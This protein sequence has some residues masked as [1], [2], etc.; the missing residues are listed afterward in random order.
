MK[1]K[2]IPRPSFSIDFFNRYSFIATLLLLSISAFAQIPNDHCFDWVRQMDADKNSKGIAIA[3]DAAGNVYSTG[4]FLGT[5]DFD[6]TTGVFN[7][8]ALGDKEDI[9][10]SK[11]DANGNF[12]W[13]K[14]MGGSLED[15]STE[16][17]VDAAGNVFTVGYFRG[18]AD[19]DPSPNSF[20]LITSNTS[21]SMFF[22]KLDTDGN[23]V[24]AKLIEGPTQPSDLTLD[25]M[26]NIYITGSFHGI[27]D[28][29]PGP[30][31][32]N[33]AMGWAQSSIF[34]LK[35][36]PTGNLAWVK[37]MGGVNTTFMGGNGGSAIR[38]DVFG[39]I[40]ISGYFIGSVDFDPGPGVFNLIVPPSGWT[41]VFVAKLNA[42]GNF[43][44][45]KQIGVGGSY[46]VRGLKL[47]AVGNV[48]TTGFFSKAL[49]FDPGPNVFN[50]TPSSSGSNAY[51][52]KLNAA[53]DFV[54][55]IQMGA[56][57]GAESIV[58]DNMDN[59]Y[60]IGNFRGNADFDPGPGVYNLDATLGNGMF[61][62]KLDALGGF[63]WAKKISNMDSEYDVT[64]LDLAMD[65][66]GCF[67][68]IG[69]FR[70][71]VDFD[72]SA[73]TNVLFTEVN[74]IFAHKMCPCLSVSAEEPF[75]STSGF[76]HSQAYPNP[77]TATTTI[78]YELPV[79]TVV[80]LTV[81]DCFGQTVAVLVD[82]HQTEGAHK[83]TFSAEGLPAGTYFYRLEAGSFREMGKI[84]VQ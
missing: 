26:G 60:T 83:A 6:P 10:V 56:L 73:G 52:L 21:I 67:Y 3:V 8:T 77:F 78:A 57:G 47:D 33:V 74:A 62:S 24:W 48:Y 61:I 20:N 35:L 66:A 80:R 43:K 46:D 55:A 41:A 36:D 12:L 9:F 63:I 58:I 28:F 75:Q 34:V 65:A 11:F 49:D 5:T 31:V 13:A 23:F 30:N 1:I 45:A 2:I 69:T 53:G 51:I 25:N 14:Q 64:P 15:Y 29:D 82:T 7:L 17:A 32:F 54:W 70:A 39:N 18:S 72:P 68:S 37:K 50:L 71:T 79:S 42:D 81:L 19:F 22:S 38:L 84:V 40:Y 27:V 16:I 4:Y 44:W 59:I 76:S